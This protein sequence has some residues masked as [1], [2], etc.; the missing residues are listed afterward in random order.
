[1][2]ASRA[3]KI[4]DINDNNA[5]VNLKYLQIIGYGVYNPIFHE[6]M[7]PNSCSKLQKESADCI[8]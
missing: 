5:K 3:D 7:H 8:S 6:S 1:M 2:R 4:F